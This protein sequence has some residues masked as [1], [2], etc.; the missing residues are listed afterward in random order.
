MHKNLVI[1]TTQL[2][3]A[4][5][6]GLLSKLSSIA[7]AIVYLGPGGN[8]KRNICNKGL[9]S[10]GFVFC[11]NCSESLRVLHYDSHHNHVFTNSVITACN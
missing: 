3:V 9:N 4:P 11:C 7:S 8:A 2:G 5:S 1:N 6:S 10:G